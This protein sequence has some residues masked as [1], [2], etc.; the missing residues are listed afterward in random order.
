VR[1]KGSANEIDAGTIMQRRELGFLEVAGLVCTIL[2]AVLA[3]A[4]W[5]VK[6][7]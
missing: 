6:V 7:F 5:M 3:I 1:P 4:D 2:A